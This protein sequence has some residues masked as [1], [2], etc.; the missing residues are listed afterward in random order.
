MSCNQNQTEKSAEVTPQV[1]S[2]EAV[3]KEMEYSFISPNA[4]VI[5]IAPLC[6]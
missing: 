5:L 2:T 1:P 4:I 6:L 3:T